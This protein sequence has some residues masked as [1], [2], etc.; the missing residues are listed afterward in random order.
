MFVF[1][2]IVRIRAWVVLIYWFL[3]QALGG[4]S[5]IN[6]LHPEIS[7]GVAVWAHVGGFICGAVMARAFAGGRGH[8]T[9]ASPAV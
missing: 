4:L 8:G 5:E 3:L 6:Q 7:G 1:V 9:R 2:F